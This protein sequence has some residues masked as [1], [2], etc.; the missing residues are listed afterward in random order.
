M[1][2]FGYFDFSF[3]DL[4]V[5]MINVSGV[6]IVIDVGIIVIIVM[7]GEVDVEGFLIFEF[8]GDFILFLILVFI[9]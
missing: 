4:F 5:V 3:F 7:L 2:V 6:L 8:I 9:L 1:V